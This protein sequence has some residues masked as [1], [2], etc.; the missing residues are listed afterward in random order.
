MRGNIWQVAAVGLLLAVALVGLN[1]TAERTT[2]AVNETDQVTVQYEGT[3][4]PQPDQRALLYYD[5][6]TVTINETGTQETLTEGTDYE[7][8][9]QDGELRFFDTA[10]TT[11]G[12]SANITYS[13]GTGRESTGVVATVLGAVGQWFGLLFLM[14]AVGAVWKL[15]AGASGGF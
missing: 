6:E 12:D 1:P 14:I 2:T 3:V 15:S 4:S 9:R 11:E 10:N 13:Y 7:W 8:D 5:N